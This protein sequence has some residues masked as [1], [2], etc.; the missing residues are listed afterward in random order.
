MFQTIAIIIIAAAVL[1]TIGGAAY[2][3]Y[4][5]KSLAEIRADVYHLFLQAEHKYTET[6][7]GKQKM[8]WV[9]SKARSLLPTWL[10]F[11]IDDEFLYEIIQVWFDAV[12]DLLD[13]G[14]MNKSSKLEEP[15]YE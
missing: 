7:S 5:D 11:I 14:K 10:Q 1:I 8:K 2:I 4:R 13:D 15:T 9:V 3:Y 6:E 12:K